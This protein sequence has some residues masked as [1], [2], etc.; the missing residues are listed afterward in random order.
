M[1][2]GG[3]DFLRY[4]TPVGSL[5]GPRKGSTHITSEVKGALRNGLVC[6]EKS[7]YICMHDGSYA[8]GFI[9]KIPSI[10]R[11]PLL[12]VVSPFVYSCWHCNYFPPTHTHSIK[13]MNHG[14]PP[15]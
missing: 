4:F 3:G 5:S 9:H 1:Q 14:M 12:L 10:G 7:S 8:P 6:I 15:L 13:A 2:P 11:L